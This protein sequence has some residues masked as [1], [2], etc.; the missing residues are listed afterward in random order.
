MAEANITVAVE[1]VLHDSLCALAKKFHSEHG[2]K[3][4][5][6]KFDWWDTSTIDQPRSSMLAAVRI[7]SSTIPWERPE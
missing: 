1:R 3:L 6:V 5:E 7:E 2:I 4:H